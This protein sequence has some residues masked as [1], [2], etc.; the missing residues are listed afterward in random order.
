MT[1]SWARLIFFAPRAETNAIEA[2]LAHNSEGGTLRRIR[3]WLNGE[4]VDT[5]SLFPGHPGFRLDLPDGAVLSGRNVLDL[6]LEGDDGAKTVEPLRVRSF[7]FLP[8]TGG[9]EESPKR[10]EVL[11]EDILMPAGGSYDVAFDV[12]GAAVLH[13]RLEA[14]LPKGSDLAMHAT[15]SLTDADGGVHSLLAED[16]ANRESVELEA[17]LDRWSGGP[18]AIRFEVSGPDSGSIRWRSPRV[19]A[20]EVA[21]P[22]PSLIEPRPVDASGRLGRPDVVIVLLDAAR[23]DA[24]SSYGGPGATPVIDQLAA[25]GTR[26]ER[27]LSPASWTAQS[28]P[29]IFTGHYPETLGVGAWSDTLSPSMPTLAE[30]LSQAGYRT[31]LWSQHPLYRHHNSLDRG[32]DE[33]LVPRRAERSRLPGPDELFIED[34]PTFAFVHFLPPHAP[35]NAPPP[36]AGIY[37]SW[38]QGALELDQIALNLYP[39]KRDPAELSPADRRFIRDRYQEKVTYADSLVGEVLDA[40]KARGRYENS[41]V[42]VVSDH[43][44]AFLEHDRFLHTELVHT[45]FVHVPFVVKWPASV[46]GFHAEVPQTVTLVDLVPTLVDGLALDDRGV[47]FQGRSLLPA[48]LDGEHAE[49][50]V[51]AM[52][53]G[54][55]RPTLPPKTKLRLEAGGY[56]GILDFLSGRLE[57]YRLA[58]DPTEVHDLAE[59]LPVLALLFKQNLLA[60]HRYNMGL[61]EGAG[62][63]GAAPDPALEDELK[64]L[65][66]L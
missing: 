17:S 25:E 34:K 14:S 53:R 40:V 3:F 55:H 23:A 52:T 57:L 30:L 37:S 18:V 26:F 54:V 61:S 22:F 46:T 15:V 39:H 64:A 11:D 47:A 36:F 50:A 51:Y 24:L 59:K 4:F 28:V 6:T 7:R 1:G 48:V 5:F 2:V 41:L 20:A 45:E 49:R 29:S 38:Y 32:F 8:H 66:Y 60:Q 31:V 9:D 44:E 33:V 16:L 42:A 43:G 27:A 58:D 12:P 62:G 35:Y 19:S 65:G 56:S 13:G 21:R 10:L 63:E